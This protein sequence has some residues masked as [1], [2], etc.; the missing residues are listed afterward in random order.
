MLAGRGLPTDSTLD[1]WAVEPKLDGWRA[2]LAID[3]ADL[4]VRSRPG[5][6]I[7][8][9]LPEFAPLTGLGLRV[10]LDGEL[11]AGAGTMDD[12]Y[13]LSGRLASRRPGGEPVLFAAFDLLWADGEDITGRT[14]MERRERLEDLSLPG[15]LVQVDPRYA[16][17][18]AELLL[19]ACENRGLEGVVLKRLASPYR[20]GQRSNDWRKVKC[21]GWAEHLERRRLAR[22]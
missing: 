22:R 9:S 13:G 17:T 7:T 3:G 16:G 6:A 4:V 20:P 15:E 10:V 5:R 8:A 1:A 2:R 11:I 14:Y 21:A 18:D 12:F 19:D